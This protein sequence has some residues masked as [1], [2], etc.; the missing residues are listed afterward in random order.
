MH[1]RTPFWAHVMIRVF[2]HSKN[3]V[4]LHLLEVTPVSSHH[5][6]LPTTGILAISNTPD[7]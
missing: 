5:Q 2:I 4:H 1:K 7:S 6:L 3:C